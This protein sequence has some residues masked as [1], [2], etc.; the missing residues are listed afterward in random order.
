MFNVLTILISLFLAS[1][2]QEALED[3]F[4]LAVD[5]AVRNDIKRKNMLDERQTVCLPQHPFVGIIEIEG[6]STVTGTAMMDYFDVYISEKAL[7]QFGTMRAAL[8]AATIALVV[9]NKVV[10]V[11]HPNN[12]I[13]RT[14]RVTV[15]D[16]DGDLDEVRTKIID[17][18]AKAKK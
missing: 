7:N 16:D 6:V 14:L 10:F 15:I 2:A 8:K 12:E 11:I 5:C 18:V 4:Y 1:P 13:E 3:G 17:Q 9:D